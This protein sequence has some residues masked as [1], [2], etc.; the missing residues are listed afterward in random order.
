[1]AS[2]GADR[3]AASPTEASRP[4]SGIKKRAVVGSFLFKIPHG[5]EKQARVA[6]FRRSGDVRTYQHKLAPLSGSVE[7]DDANPMA[8]ALREI[9]EETTLTPASLELLRVGK[10]YSFTDDSI[11]RE[12]TINPFAFRLKDTAE[13]GKGEAGITLDWEHEGIE[14]F[15]PLD[16]K[17]SDEFGGVPKLVNSLRR[18]WPEYDL[19]SRAG[20]TLTDGLQTLRNDHESGAR[21]LAAISLSILKGIVAELD[22]TSLDE[23]WW[24]NI[25]MAA[26][27]LCKVRE[28]MGAAITTAIVKALDQIEAA[29]LVTDLTPAEKVRRMIEDLDTQLD[30]RNFA[31]NQIADSLV[32]YL[33]Q[34]V[35]SGAEPKKSISILT[36]SYSS[37]ISNCLLQA[38]SSLGVSLDLRVLESRPLY[39]GVTLASKVLEAGNQKADMNITLHSDAS[40]AHAA[41]GIDILVLG[42]DRLSSAGDVSNKIGSLPAVLSARHVA[43]QSKVVILSE[44]EKIARPGSMNE[45]ESEEND[46]AELTRAWQGTVKG[47]NTIQ[48]ALQVARSGS[49]HPRVTVK[50]IYFEWIPA[51]LVDAYATEEGIW[52]VEEIAKRSQWISNEMD[53]FFKDL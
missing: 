31:T 46:P 52:A 4:A 36:L 16:V 45:H 26:W 11:G 41:R 29:F 38:V 43:P 19:G 51:H 1:M 14:W 10:P 9:Q 15:D 5:D 49:E 7:P 33:R 24:A 18:V 22:N 50:N 8:T 32:A 34:S 25:R 13:G 53:R 40:V 37:T 27:H 2:S 12:W 21:Q 3:A 23:S 42:A 48:D 44:T 28:S 39:E 6:L 17:D 35:L 20:K 47:V 30:K